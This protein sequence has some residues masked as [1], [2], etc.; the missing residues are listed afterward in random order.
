LS[1]AFD[2]VA[3]LLAW[4][5]H[6]LVEKY[7]L[8]RR[9]LFLTAGLPAASAAAHAV[10]TQG[11]FNR[12]VDRSESNRAAALQPGRTPSRLNVR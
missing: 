4:I 9:L 2:L 1:I 12:L 7:G 8:E 5:C 3:A 10:S 11:D 6:G